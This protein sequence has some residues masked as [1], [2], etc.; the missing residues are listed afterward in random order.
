MRRG[1]V[2][3]RFGCLVVGGR[4]LPAQRFFWAPPRQQQA[5]PTHLTCPS[6]PPLLLPKH[7]IHCCPFLSVPF[8]PSP[9]LPSPGLPRRP[10]VLSLLP[11]PF[12]SFLACL[13][14]RPLLAPFPPLPGFDLPRRPQ[15][16]QTGAGPPGLPGR[17]RGGDCE[18]GPRRSEC[19]RSIEAMCALCR[20]N[21]VP[22][23]ASL[24]RAVSACC[25]VAFLGCPQRAGSA[26]AAGCAAQQ[27]RCTSPCAHLLTRHPM[28]SAT[29]LPMHPP[30]GLPPNP[31]AQRLAS[32]VPTCSLPHTCPHPPTAGP[33]CQR[34]EHGRRA[35]AD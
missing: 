18:G 17:T 15:G 27:T 29:R 4:P 8:F 35:G 19:A 28:R 33:F 26:A 20:P 21:C 25:S 9:P 6:P 3:D 32:H 2:R 13:A 7:C 16:A 22:A 23:L 11:F 14:H 24:D 30:T 34:A 5:A 12:L 31:S 1:L 10:Q